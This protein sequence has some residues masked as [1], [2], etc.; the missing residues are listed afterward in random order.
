MGQ[1]S[2]TKALAA[3]A[4][5]AMSDNY[6]NRSF[7]GLPPEEQRKIL[8]TIER[9]VGD[10]PAPWDIPEFGG[11]YREGNY[12]GKGFSLRMRALAKELDKP[13]GVFPSEFGGKMYTR[14]EAIK[15]LEEAGLTFGGEEGARA[16]QARSHPRCAGLRELIQQL[17]IVTSIGGGIYSRRHS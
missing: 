10:L 1:E 12:S 2:S 15:E 6:L 3:A 7:L 17:E 5:G 14:E 13:D 11:T 9:E 4:F 16:G 8:D